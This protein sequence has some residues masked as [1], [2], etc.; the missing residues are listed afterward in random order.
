[1]AG[2]DQAPRHAAQ[3]PRVS[4]PGGGRRGRDGQRAGPGLGGRWQ[5]GGPRH[6]LRGC[7]Q[8]RRR[9]AGARRRGGRGPG[10]GHS[11]QP[12]RP[13]AGWRRACLQFKHL[14]CPDSRCREQGHRLGHRVAGAVGARSQRPDTLRGRRRSQEPGSG[15]ESIRVRV[16]GRC[17]DDPRRS[18]RG[19]PPAGEAR[20]GGR[21]VR[22]IAPPGCR[23]QVGLVAGHRGP[24]L[25]PPRHACGR[26]VGR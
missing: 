26:R 23:E 9:G 15:P 1:M 16:L 24:R 25:P 2:S 11:C 12:G 18:A 19:D 20:G 21:G 10:S 13:S 5:P 14:Q 17:G 22:G 4:L 8:P 7:C 6:C 3:R